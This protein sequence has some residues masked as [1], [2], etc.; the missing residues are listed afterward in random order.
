M[1]GVFSR[2]TSLLL[3]VSTT[4]LSVSCTMGPKYQRPAIETP[5]QFR[6]ATAT[7]AS[8]ESLGDAQWWEVFQDETL[9]KLIQAALDGSPSMEIAAARVAQAQAQLGITRADQFPAI[10]ASGSVGRQKSAGMSIFPG[11]EANSAQLGLSAV[12]QLDFWG[13]YR[14]ATEAARAQ[15]MATEWGQKA[16]VASL[17]A[18]VAAAYFQLRELDLELDVSRR[19]LEARRESLELN[20]TL[21]RGGAISLMDVHQAEILV[22]Q[23]ATRIPNL[24]TR[25]AQQENLLSTLLGRNPSEIERGQQI[26]EQALP[27]SIPAGLPSALLERRP[28]LQQAEWQLVAAN[29][30]IGVAKA[31]WFPQISL[32]GSG[33]YQAFGIENLFDSKVYNAGL[34]LTQPIFEFGRIR[35]GVRLSEAQKEELAAAYR[36]A[37]QQAFADV[38]D[39]LV[40]ASKSRESRER[41]LA[42]QQAASRAA[43]LS[44]VRYRGGVTTY[45]EVLQSQT[46]LFDAEIGLA[47]SELNERLAI[48]QLYAALGGGWQL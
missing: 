13:R 31:A 17:V 39:A 8:K 5:D 19:T 9:R 3:L 23:A 32:T 37:V 4:A 30:R 47:Q 41:Q 1:S 14:K 29:A 24:E 15:M 48:V 36:Q 46:N 26:T 35:S 21:E 34:N 10:G 6:G 28:D 12:W 11:Y 25:I 27:P 22:E 20:R 45:L 33:G 40:A 44:D 38:S 42:L 43:A 18:S 2:R 16:V 7:E